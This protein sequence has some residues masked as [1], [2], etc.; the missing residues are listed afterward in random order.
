[1]EKPSSKTNPDLKNAITPTNSERKTFH[2]SPESVL[3]KSSTTQ[4]KCLREAANND[5]LFE[6]I[7]SLVGLSPTKKIASGEAAWIN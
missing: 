2:D 6:F 7:D 1:M 3:N 5:N 4:L